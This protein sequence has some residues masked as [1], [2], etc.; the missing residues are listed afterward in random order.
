MANYTLD[1][2]K[3]DPSAGHQAML[4]GKRNFSSDENFPAH[5]RHP[6]NII[7]FYDRTEDG[8][9]LWKHSE[10]YFPRDRLAYGLLDM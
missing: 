7:C 3:L 1:V 9:L 8:V 6:E 10:G 4:H 5:G 2:L